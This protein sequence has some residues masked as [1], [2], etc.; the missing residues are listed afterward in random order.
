MLHLE[1]VHKIFMSRVSCNNNDDTT[2][3]KALAGSVPYRQNVATSFA[4]ASLTLKA[5]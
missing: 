1:S 2:I 4:T 5:V 3:C